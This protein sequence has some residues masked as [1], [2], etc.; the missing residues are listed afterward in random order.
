[1]NWIWGLPGDFL[2]GCNVD[3]P[4]RQFRLSEQYND[5]VEP[6]DE[7]LRSYCFN[8]HSSTKILSHRIERPLISSIKTLKNSPIICR[9]PIDMRH[10]RE[11]PLHIDENSLLEN[12]KD[13]SMGSGVEVIDV[14]PPEVLIF[15]HR[16]LKK[17]SL[18][19]MN[20]LWLSWWTRVSFRQ[21]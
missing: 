8:T 4:L 21:A 19:L 18:T 1:M 2:Q 7:N 14:F 10:K 3:H 20:I 17:K 11:F 6:I 15:L 13:Y 16:C 12:H 9:K 5:K